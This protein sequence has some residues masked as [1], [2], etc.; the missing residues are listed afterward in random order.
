[1]INHA[2]GLRLQ[3]ERYIIHILGLTYRLWDNEYVENEKKGCWDKSGK[4]TN[5]PN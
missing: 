4:K 1:M 5:T 2:L 3:F